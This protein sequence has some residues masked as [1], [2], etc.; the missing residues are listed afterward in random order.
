MTL[1]TRARRIQAVALDIDGVLTDGRIGYASGTDEIKFFDVRDGLGIKLLQRAG[2]KVGV[3]SGRS[4]QA[5]RT[6][7]AELGL[8]FATE[9][10]R[11]KATAL[12][13]LASQLGIETTEILFI[14][15]DLVDLP[16][17]NLAGVSV[18]VGDAVDE[19]KQAVDLVTERLGGR[20]AIREAAEWLLREQGKW[21]AIVRRY[22]GKG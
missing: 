17:M 9:G 3:L 18:A 6:R 12:R 22:Q 2:L 15:D 5:N 21:I 14:G 13:E 10:S 11:D 4:S 20:G 7:I 16:A 1:S 8:D 19:V